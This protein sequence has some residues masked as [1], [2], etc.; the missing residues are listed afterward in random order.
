MIFIYDVFQEGFPKINK[1]L[2]IVLNML[3]VLT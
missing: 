2:P 1:D 3:L